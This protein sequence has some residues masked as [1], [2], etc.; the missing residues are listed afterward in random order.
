MRRKASQFIGPPEPLLRR[1]GTTH[2]W[3][4]D[5]ENGESV[6]VIKTIELQESTSHEYFRC[7][8]IG[9]NR[10]VYNALVCLL[11]EVTP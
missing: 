2:V 4:R 11:A 9:I 3:F 7:N 5:R 6:V 10:L 1:I 8:G